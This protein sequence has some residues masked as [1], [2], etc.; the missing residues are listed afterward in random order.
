MLGA[1]LLPAERILLLPLLFLLSL[2]ASSGSP[3]P[4]LHP[5]P[6]SSTR[7]DQ[8][9]CASVPESYRHYHLIILNYLIILHMRLILYLFI[10]RESIRMRSRESST[11]AA[12]PVMHSSLIFQ[13]GKPRLSLFSFIITCRQSYLWLQSNWCYY[14]INCPTISHH[15]NDNRY[16][17]LLL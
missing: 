6:P 15:F 4:L 14:P 12:S 2:T 13:H 8:T 1:L 11:L 17:A 9:I 3:E 16:V 5:A 7:Q 10:G